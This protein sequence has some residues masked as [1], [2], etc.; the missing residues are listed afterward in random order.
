MRDW[1]G[2]RRD[3][4]STDDNPIYVQ[5][6]RYWVNGEMQRRS[7]LERYAQQSGMTLTNF[8]SANGSYF[9]IFQD[10]LG[11]LISEVAS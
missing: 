3:T 4:V 10:A 5:N 2:I 7:G 1:T 6:A 8:A 11:N 9:V